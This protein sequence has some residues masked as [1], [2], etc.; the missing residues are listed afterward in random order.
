MHQA[1]FSLLL[2]ALFFVG[3]ST[4]SAQQQDHHPNDFNPTL[5]LE[6]FFGLGKALVAT[7]E[8][9]QTHTTHY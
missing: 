4:A 3:A 9:T 1:F 2:P 6:P 7:K 5:S 8:F